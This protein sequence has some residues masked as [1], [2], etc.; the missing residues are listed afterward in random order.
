MSC[1][2]G[3]NKIPGAGPFAIG[4]TLVEFVLNAH[5]GSVA[6]SALPGGGLDIDCQGCGKHFVLDT[7]VKGCPSCGGVHAVSPPRAS[8]PE[9]VQFAGSDFKL[10]N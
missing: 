9:A 10:N 6:N 1:D 3:S 5:G 7:F 4:K 8:D 2:C